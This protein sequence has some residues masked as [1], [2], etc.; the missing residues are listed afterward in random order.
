ML[1]V[2]G[3][4]GAANGLIMNLTTGGATSVMVGNFDTNGIPGHT[5]LAGDAP[6][7]AQAF[8]SQTNA[9]SARRRWRASKGSAPVNRFT[10]AIGDN[11]TEKWHISM[12]VGLAAP[13]PLALTIDA[14][15]TLSGV[16][17]LFALRDLV[18]SQAF[19]GGIVRAVFSTAA[20]TLDFAGALAA[21]TVLSRTI[22]GATSFAGAISRA[23][24]LAMA[25]VSSVA[26]DLTR[27]VARALD[28]AKSFA[29]ALDTVKA[30]LRV[31]DGAASFAGDIAAQA[32]PQR[33]LDGAVAFAGA[34]ALAT[35]RTLTAAM[36][37]AG[38]LVRATQRTVAA[39][40]S[41]AGAVASQVTFARVVDG[42]MSFAGTAAGVAQKSLDATLLYA[43]SLARTVALSLLLAGIVTTNGALSTLSQFFRAVQGVMDLTGALA[44]VRLVVNVLTLQSDLSFTK[45]LERFKRRMR[46]RSIFP[47]ADPHRRYPPR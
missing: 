28:G 35:Q 3:N 18:A 13:G 2:G 31:V 46:F 43:R 1:I 38:A 9:T 37:F 27:S 14:V 17:A 20:G 42:A 8:F 15:L 5:M 4:P 33:V 10:R 26:G 12:P 19:A 22:D 16:P 47:G 25:G 44:A 45:Q 21:T 11:A 36:E 40:A 30:L 24:Q 23:V 6:L 7:A 29:G 41:F 34:T 32:A 39:G